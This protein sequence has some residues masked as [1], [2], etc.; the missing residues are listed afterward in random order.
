MSVESVGSV[1][2]LSASGTMPVPGAVGH[3]G[4]VVRSTTWDGPGGVAFVVA[5]AS[6]VPP[7]VVVAEVIVS[8][9]KSHVPKLYT[10]PT[11][12]GL[13][14]Y[15]FSLAFAD[16]F[17]LD[18]AFRDTILIEGPQAG[19]VLAQVRCAPCLPLVSLGM[20]VLVLP[21]TV[22]PSTCDGVQLGAD[23]G[24]VIVPGL[25]ESVDKCCFKL[26]RWLVVWAGGWRQLF[27]CT[28][29]SVEPWCRPCQTALWTMWTWSCG[30]A[31]RQPTVALGTVAT[32]S[33]VPT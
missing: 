13:G 25:F 3:D 15:R 17:V 6:Q 10:A 4:A 32:S 33:V 31:L 23:T 11:N 16:R 8:T 24:T 20:C 14:N 22:L 30:F 9:F 26:G 2:S 5:G 21:V 27:V 18:Q 12:V 1:R 7:G 28:P 29:Y 19:T